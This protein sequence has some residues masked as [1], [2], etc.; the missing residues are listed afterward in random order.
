MS[1]EIVEISCENISVKVNFLKGTEEW[2][3]EDKILFQGQFKTDKLGQIL[4]GTWI[5]K[6]SKAVPED[7]II[8]GTYCKGELVLIEGDDDT[9]IRKDGFT[10]RK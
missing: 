7:I 8:S 6:N 5:Y 10:Y 9:D 1:E 2:R 3:E 4:S